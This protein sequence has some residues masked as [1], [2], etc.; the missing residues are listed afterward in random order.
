M[1]SVVSY[2]VLLVMVIAMIIMLADCR[3]GFSRRRFQEK[4]LYSC[5]FVVGCLL[6]VLLLYAFDLLLWSE[7]WILLGIAAIL[8]VGYFIWIWWRRQKRMAECARARR[9]LN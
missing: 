4:L 3:K 9:M 5:I 1:E 2:L 7:L 8:D 6:G